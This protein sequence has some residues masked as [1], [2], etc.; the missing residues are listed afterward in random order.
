MSYNPN[1]KDQQK[2]RPAD[3]KID[4]KNRQPGQQPLKPEDL[5]KG[6]MGSSTIQKPKEPFVKK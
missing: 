3:Q 4:Q 6:G 2:N 1:Q 5:K